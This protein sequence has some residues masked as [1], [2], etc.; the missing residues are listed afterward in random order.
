[1]QA[2]TTGC[3]N[4]SCHWFIT[5]WR[6]CSRLVQVCIGHANAE[7][8]RCVLLLVSCLEGTPGRCSAH[9]L[10]PDCDGRSA[11]WRA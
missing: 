7:G 5:V 8:C 4:F 11:L 1:M 10:S 9:S 6:L 2:G 3:G